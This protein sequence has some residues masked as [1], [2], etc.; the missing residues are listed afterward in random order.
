MDGA[1]FV[2]EL[3]NGPGMKPEDNVFRSIWAEYERVILQSLV[4]SF[5]LDFLVHDQHGGDVDTIHNVREIGSDSKME[6]KN[7][8]NAAAYDARGEYDTAGFTGHDEK[9]QIVL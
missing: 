4:T 2:G 1:A 5:G 9:S 6:Y 8:A 7:A 3:K